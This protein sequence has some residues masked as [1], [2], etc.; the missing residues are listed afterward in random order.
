MKKLQVIQSLHSMSYI[1]L[2]FLCGYV[3]CCCKRLAYCK[4]KLTYR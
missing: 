3:V 1:H 2:H 4:Y